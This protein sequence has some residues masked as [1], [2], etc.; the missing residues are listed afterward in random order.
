MNNVTIRPE[1]LGAAV[2][3]PFA[4]YFHG[5]PARGMMYPKATKEKANTEHAEEIRKEEPRH[6]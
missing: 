3:D 1:L 6:E 2:F 5:T 4:A